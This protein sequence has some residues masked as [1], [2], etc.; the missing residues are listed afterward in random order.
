FGETDE[1]VNKKAEAAFKHGL[2]PI[3]CVGETLEEREGG[4]TDNVVI[5]Q[6]QKALHGLSAEQIATLLIA[7]EPVWAIG[8]GKTCDADEANRVCRVIRDTVQRLADEATASRV[9]ILYGGS[10]KADTIAEQM[11]KP[12]IDGALVGGASLEVE[13]FAAIVNFEAAVK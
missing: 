2:C 8:T 6:T 4:L 9:R 3:V 12:D 5:I 11:S 13:S 1:E 7:Y 10:V